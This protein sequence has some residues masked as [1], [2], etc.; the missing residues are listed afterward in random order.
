MTPLLAVTKREFLSLFRTPT[1]WLIIALYLMLAGAVFSLASLRPGAPASLRDFFSIS[2]WLLLFIAPAV[3]MRTIA[4]E[5]RTGTIEP[6]LSAP[7]SEWQ[8]V[9]GKAL[10]AWLFIAIMLLPTLAYPALLRSLAPLDLAASLVGYAGLLLLALLYVCVGVLCSACSTSQSSAFLATVASLVLLRLV[11]VQAA[12]FL[13]HPFDGALYAL[14]PELRLADFAKGVLDTS[15]LV[16]FAA[17]ST[18]LLTL[19]VVTLEARRWR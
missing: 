17:V 1:G 9:P 8:I 7:V 19:A 13:P 5:R 14:S 16:Y 10:A 2:Q 11:T 6:L 15:H 4:E 3:S 18:F 12:G